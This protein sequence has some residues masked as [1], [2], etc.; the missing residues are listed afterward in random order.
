LQKQIAKLQDDIR[1]TD[2]KLGNDQFVSNAPPE[3]IE[4]F[5]TRKVDALSTIEKLETAL[6]QL[7]A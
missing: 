6:S 4:E 1:K 5:K 7:A 3:I 2:E